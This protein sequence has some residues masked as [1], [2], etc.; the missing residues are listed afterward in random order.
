MPIV[1][2]ACSHAEPQIEPFLT[3]LAGNGSA[4]RRHD[5]LIVPGHFRCVLGPTPTSSDMR[6]LD[7]IDASNAV[8][9]PIG[10]TTGFLFVRRCTL[11]N[12]RRIS[13]TR[14]RPP[15]EI[16]FRSR[17]PAWKTCRGLRVPMDAEETQN[18]CASAIGSPTVRLSQQIGV[19]TSPG[20]RANDF[21]DSAVRAAA[22]GLSQFSCRRKGDCP[23]CRHLARRRLHRHR[24]RYSP[25]AGQSEVVSLQSL[26]NRRQT[27]RIAKPSRTG[28][29]FP[30]YG[31]LLTICRIRLKSYGPPSASQRGSSPTWNATRQVRAGRPL[32][33]QGVV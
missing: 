24:N 12:P 14:L 29:D 21:S 25:A 2:Q 8:K 22:R 23:P 6:S 27:A 30:S 5:L 19:S 13:S 11:P 28:T 32:T 10:P 33:V 1:V 7:S 3:D 20:G 16:L 31:R 9:P 4:Q 15:R 26:P 18:H 17:Q